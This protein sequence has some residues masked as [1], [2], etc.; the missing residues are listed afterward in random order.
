MYGWKKGL[1]TGSYYI[2]SKPARNAV[3]F[4]ILPMI[5]TVPEKVEVEEGKEYVKNGVKYICTDDVCINCGS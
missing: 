5:E 2:R 1:K 4:S 3:K